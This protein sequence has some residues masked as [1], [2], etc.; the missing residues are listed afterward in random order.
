MQAL[1]HEQTK[2]K[3]ESEGDKHLEILFKIVQFWGKIYFES[4]LQYKRNIPH[5]WAHGL[6]FLYATFQ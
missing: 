4:E 6:K 1:G 5:L 2:S 3:L